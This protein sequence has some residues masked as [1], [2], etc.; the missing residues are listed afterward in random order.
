MKTKKPKDGF[1]ASYDAARVRMTAN[2]DGTLDLKAGVRTFR[3]VRVK[4]GRPLYKPADFAS[5]LGEKGE[6]GL[7]VNLAGL[8]PE[9]RA[10]LEEHRLQGDLTTK[11]LK[12]NDISHQFGA[13]YWEVQ[14][15]KGVRQFVIRGTSEHVRWLDD[16]RLLI[17]DVNGNRFEIPSLNALDKRSL[18]HIHLIL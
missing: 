18:D 10:I 5:I 17:T 7:L 16:D 15:A 6:V 2:P 4:L 1:P 11:V 14:T 13:S 3:K 9:A 8:H 12:I